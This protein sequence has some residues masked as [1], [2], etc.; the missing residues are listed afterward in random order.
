MPCAA[1]CAVEV[2]HGPVREAGKPSQRALGGKFDL[3]GS[4]AHRAVARQA[5]RESLVLLKNQG[6]VL[7][8]QPK[9][10]HPGRG[11]WRRRRGQAVRWLDADL[12]G[13]RHQARRLPECRLDLGRLP[14]SRS[15]PPAATPSSPRT[16]STRRSP[17]SPSWCSVRIPTPNSRA[18]C[19]TCCSRP[20]RSGDLELIKRL[21][22]DGI[23]VV[24]VFLSGRPLWM[25][26]E[27]NAADAFVAAWLP[28]S[29]GAGV[30]DVLLRKAGRQ[31]AAR[32]PRQAELFVAAH[33]RPVRQQRRAEGLRPAVRVR[34]RP[35]LRATRASLPR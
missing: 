4:P 31:R 30:A 14:P 3:L 35:A 17:M 26:R 2:A 18:T 19:P 28:G 25:N 6:G 15:R 27:I 8:L 9:A 7:P 32:L 10:T 33:A 16:A 13:H 5:V 22:A 29:E 12:A 21:K 1:S 34:L 24:A 11:R 20:A 23:P